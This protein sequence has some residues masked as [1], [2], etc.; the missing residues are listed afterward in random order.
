MDNIYLCRCNDEYYIE[1]SY[2]T[3]AYT[4]PPAAHLSIYMRQVA[5]KL[6]GL[7]SIVTSLIEESDKA[8]CEGEGAIASVK[9]K[10]AFFI[11]ADITEAELS[12]LMSHGDVNEAI[13]VKLFKLDPDIF[14]N[15]KI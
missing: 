11:K 15:I 13:L 10:N 14:S 3:P 9:A 5:E 6:K 12:S 1:E 2:S 7:A 8:S 4:V